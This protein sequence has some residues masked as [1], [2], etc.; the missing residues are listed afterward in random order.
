MK[1]WVL[2]L[3]VIVVAAMIYSLTGSQLVTSTR[4]KELIRRGATVVDVRTDIEWNL[5]H[6]PKAVH[7]PLADIPYQA[8]IKNKDTVLVVY[9]NSGQRARTGAELLRAQGFTHTH[10]IASTYLSLIDE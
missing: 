9:C 7:I 1:T 2:I 10:Y 3:A 5:G 8:Q 4:A 6:H